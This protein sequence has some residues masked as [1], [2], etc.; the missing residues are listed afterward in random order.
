MVQLT[1]LKSKEDVLNPVLREHFLFAVMKDGVQKGL[2]MGLKDT[3]TELQMVYFGSHY[4]LDS[5]LPLYHEA[6][7]QKVAYLE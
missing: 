2:M 3:E 6:L 1:E 5:A 4:L 7:S